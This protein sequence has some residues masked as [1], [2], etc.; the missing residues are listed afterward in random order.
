M[1]RVKMMNSYLEDFE[2][3]AEELEMK[4]AEIWGEKPIP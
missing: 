3:Q 4:L 1:S 2:K